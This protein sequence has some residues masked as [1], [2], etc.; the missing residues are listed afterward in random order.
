MLARLHAA[1][2]QRG[3]GFVWALVGQ[4]GPTFLQLIYFIIAARILGADATGSFFLIVAVAVIGSSFVGLGA[5]G[6]VLRE[7]SRDPACAAQVFGQAQAMSLASFPLMLPLAAAGAW[8]VTDGQIALW[9]IL[10]IVSADLLAGRMLTTSWSLFVAR[11]QQLRAAL[12]ICLMP[13]ARMGVCLLAAYWPDP[14]RLSVFAALYFLASFAVLAMVLGIMRRVIGPQPLSLAGFDF[15]N[16]ISFS[17]TWLNLA[18]QSEGDK[19][20]L[21]LFASPATVA[22]YAIAA[23][24]MDGAAMV[25]RALRVLVQARLFRA[26]AGGSAA[27]FQMS[28]RL[29]PG[30][31]AYGC[32]VWLAFWLLAPVFAHIFGP[33]FEGLARIL[34]ILGALPLLRGI[35]EFGAEIFMSSDRAAVQAITQTAMTLSR[36]ALGVLL[37]A[38]FQIEGAIA[39]ALIISAL[40]GVILW[41]IAFYQRGRK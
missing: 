17:A 2:S 20:L 37:I 39:T 4:A 14:Q 41:A 21:G 18:L 3:M 24:L 9:V 22:V 15:R 28:L 19:L 38:A 33:G 8:Y 13:L 7:V 34:P 27:A 36:V 5:G 12:L 10:A 16:G 23:R 31:V 25:P 11:E 32:V 1:F 40:S 35:A 26:G 29:L 30:V 6:L